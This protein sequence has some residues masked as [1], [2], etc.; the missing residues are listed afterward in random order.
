V[1][2]TNRDRHP[3]NT[4]GQRIPRQKPPAVQRFNF[5]TR[6]KAKATQTMTLSLA[7]LRPVHIHD[8]RDPIQGQ[9]VQLHPTS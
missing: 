9:C 7:K 8:P 3:A 2:Q 1:G 6:F 5:D 4:H